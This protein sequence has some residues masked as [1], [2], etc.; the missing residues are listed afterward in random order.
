MNRQ[1][2]TIRVEDHGEGL[3]LLTLNRPEVANALNT[4]MGRDLLAF[5]DAI[6]AARHFLTDRL[7]QVPGVD[8]VRSMICM[9]EVKAPSPL[10]VDLD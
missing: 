2:E 7:M 1:Y 10:P 3:L 8:D 4:Q 9:E 6:N 5:F